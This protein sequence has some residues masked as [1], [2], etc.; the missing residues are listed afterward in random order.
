[1]LTA[2][3]LKGLQRRA[4][5]LFAAE[6]AALFPPVVIILMACLSATPLSYV[7]LLPWWLVPNCSSAC[8]CWLL[9]PTSPA[10]VQCAGAG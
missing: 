4:D 1:M 8:A 6:L 5:A 3:T 2:A 7:L 9:P 10:G